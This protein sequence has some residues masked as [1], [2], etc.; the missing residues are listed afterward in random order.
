MSAYLASTKINNNFTI[1]HLLCRST[2]TFFTNWFD[3]ASFPYLYGSGMMFPCADHN[4][5]ILIYPSV[6]GNLFIGNYK[7]GTGLTW[8]K[9]TTEAE[10]NNLLKQRIVD[11]SQELTYTNDG[12]ESYA[13]YTPPSGYVLISAALVNAPNGYFGIK[14]IKHQTGGTYTICL[15]WGY[16]GKWATQLIIAKLG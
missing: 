2:I 6:S 16:S 12:T 11:T 14:L 3:A 15:N 9:L 13:T 8:H 5:K 1:N 4:E 10:V 7:A